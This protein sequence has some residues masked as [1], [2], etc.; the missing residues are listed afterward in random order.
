MTALLPRL[1]VAGKANVLDMLA[2]FAGLLGG[3]LGGHIHIHIH[4]NIFYIRNKYILHGGA[5]GRAAKPKIC[6]R[7]TLAKVWLS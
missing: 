7:G 2:V 5:G 1:A 4:T 6:R 3:W